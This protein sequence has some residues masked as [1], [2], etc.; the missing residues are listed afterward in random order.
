MRTGTALA[1]LVLAL[2]SFSAAKPQSRFTQY[3]SWNTEMYPV[4]KE[5]DPRYKD[6]WKGGKV[7]FIVGNDAPTLTGAKVTFTIELQFPPNQKTMPDGEVVWADNCTI[8]GTTYHQS[9]PVFPAP[10]M[11]WNGVFPDGA[12]F[13]MGGD[14][15]PPYVFV[16]KTW[17]QYWQVSDGASSSLTI[18]TDGVPLGSYVV[19]IVIYHYRSREKFIPLGYASTQFSITDQI[20]FAVSMTQVNDI[21]EADLTF[22]QNRAIAFT[23]SLHDPSAYLADADITYNWDFGDSSGAL[24]SREL[25]VTHTYIVAGGFR[26]KVVVQAV[27]PDK[28]C[29]TPAGADPTGNAIPVAPV[30]PAAANGEDF[31]IG[32]CTSDKNKE[33]SLAANAAARPVIVATLGVTVNM[34]PTEDTEEDVTAEDASSAQDTKT[35]SPGQ[36]TTVLAPVLIVAKRESG[37][38]P[39][40]E[41]C[42]IYRYGSFCTGIDVVE[43]IEGLKI[44]QVDK[45]VIQTEESEMEQHV[46]D[47]TVT[48]HGSLPTEVCTVVSD[49]DCLMPVHTMCNSVA[50]SS[51][52]QLVLRHFFNDSGIFCINVS[53]TNDVSLAVTSAKVSVTVG[54]SLSSVGTVTMVLGILVVAII[55]GT[56]AYTYKRFKAYR[57]L[58][59]DSVVGSAPKNPESSSSRSPGLLLFWKLL[60]RQVPVENS[61]LID[62]RLV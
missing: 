18:G 10:D 60:S 22:I 58:K 29:A 8:N 5:E 47:L 48:C 12:P 45:T 51:D 35:L 38:K 46:V 41:D 31:V 1:V 28:T 9:E 34:G 16:W 33:R 39:K 24:I 15:P 25:T 32:H 59:E 43:G 44:V 4:W 6:S 37:D 62:D 52:C 23:I 14:K 3:P 56:V 36:A 13:R 7:K 30:N 21:H 54:T 17:G 50:P 42:V 49:A 61:P 11:E 57:P 40:D 53:M 26:P 20:P 2:F 19:D 27:I 55:A